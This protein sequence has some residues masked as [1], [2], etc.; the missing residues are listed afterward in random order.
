DSDP[1]NKKPRKMP[2]LSAER[3]HDRAAK[4]ADPIHAGEQ[5]D[6]DGSETQVILADHRDHGGERPAKGIVDHGDDHDAAQSPVAADEHQPLDHAFEHTG[7]ARWCRGVAMAHP[8]RYRDRDEVASDADDKSTADAEGR[9]QDAADDRAEHAARVVGA[10]ID[11]HR[12]PPS[13]RTDDLHDHCAAYRIVGC[14]GDAADKAREG[15]L[16]DL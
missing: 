6:A 16:P 14:P 4:S 2:L 13:F 1:A 8:E 3:N 10:D 12:R 9:E 15:Q 5:T 7:T 11:R